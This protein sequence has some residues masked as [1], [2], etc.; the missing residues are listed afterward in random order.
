MVEKWNWPGA[1]AFA[2]IV[3]L[4]L[5]PVV[6]VAGDAV[7]FWIYVQ[8]PIYMLHQ[9]FVINSVGVWGVDLAALYL[10][11]FVNPGWGLVAMYLPLVNVV[12][13]VGQAVALRRYNPGLVSAVILFVP[14]A[15][16]GLWVVTRAAEPTRLT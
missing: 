6:W 7:S 9:I 10:V 11:V 15:G 4:A 14:V 13:H 5:A 1:A 16:T 2:G 3:L 12:G 8:L